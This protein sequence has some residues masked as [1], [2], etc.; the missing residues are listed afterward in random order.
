MD[1][2]LTVTFII[3][4]G[5]KRPQEPNVVI[6]QRQEYYRISTGES[7]EVRCVA[8]HGF[9]TPRLYWVRE[10]N[11]PLSRNVSSR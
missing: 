2:N 4:A 1:F 6:E 8:S 9:P 10:D 5:H 11:K 3:I 7:I